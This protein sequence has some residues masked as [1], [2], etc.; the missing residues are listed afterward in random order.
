MALLSLVSLQLLLLSSSADA[1]SV[2][3]PNSRMWSAGRSANV[4]V[5]SADP[6]Q[7]QDGEII[8]SMDWLTDGLANEKNDAPESSDMS[9]AAAYM[10]EHEGGGDLGDVPIPTT[11]VSVSDEMERANKDRFFTELVPIR[12]LSKGVRAAQIVT[13]ATSGSFDPVRYLVGLSKKEEGE[14]EATDDSFVMVDVPPF[15]NRLK[16]TMQQ[17]MGKGKLAAILVTSRDCI[18]Y[19]D[20]P[21]V[22]T[23]RRADVSHWARAFPDTEIVTYRLDTPR[24]CR[25]FVT[26]QL[27]GYGPFALQE[28]GMGS[29]RNVTFVETGRPLT[30]EEWDHDVIQDILAGKRKPPDDNGDE[31]VEENI[32]SKEDEQ[33]RYSPEAIRAREE[34]K[35]VLAVYTPGRSFGSVSYV[36]PEIQLVASGFTIPVEDNREDTNVGLDSAGPALDCRGYITT[37]RAGISRQTESARTLIQN[38]ADRFTVILPSARGDPFFLDGNTED[39][40]TELLDIVDQYEKIGEIYE[41]LGITGGGDGIY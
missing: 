34:G 16:S 41:Q 3:R 7:N 19:D 18:H 23:I 10:E 22:F 38:Y 30:Y 29:S 5:L 12:G 28:E 14:S 8:P 31:T 15:S 40:K 17:Y 9:K 4:L 27:D 21:G 33:D 1:F 39:R 35:R 25:Q 37:S 13:S 20:A 6:S 24:D 26:Q 36:F 11:G 32:E 2:T